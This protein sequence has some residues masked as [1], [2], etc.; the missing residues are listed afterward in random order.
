MGGLHRGPRQGRGILGSA[1]LLLVAACSGGGEAGGPAGAPTPPDLG[2]NMTVDFEEGDT[3]ARFELAAPSVASFVFRATLPVPRGFLVDGQVVSPLFLRNGDGVSVPAQVEVVSRYANPADGADVVEVL[4]RVARPA[5]ASPGDRI[6]YEAVWRPHAPGAHSLSDDVVDL[7]TPLVGEERTLVLR[8]T[9]VFGHRYE[10]DLLKDLRAGDPLELRT[11]RDG[12]YARQVRTHENLEPVVP[13]GGATG[14]LPHL[15]GV[16]TYLTTW[17]DADFVSIDLRLHNGHDGGDP[18]TDAD[19]PMGKLYFEE[20]ELVVPD[21][22]TLHQAFDD[23]TLGA[24]YL[25]GGSRVTELIAP[26]GDGSMHVFPLQQL[27]HRRLVLCRPGAEAEALATLREENLG[28]CRDEDIDGRR[29]LSWWNPGTA[30]Y[31]AQ[32]LPL[33]RLDSWK[34]AADARTWLDGQFVAA[35]DALEGGGTGPFPIDYPNLGWAHPWGLPYGGFHGGTEIFFWDGVRTAW[36]AS[37]EG[38]RRF[39]IKHRMYT[40]RHRTALYDRHG[41]E[42]QLEDW[43]V[44]GAGETYLMTWMWLTPYLPMADVHGFTQAPTFQVEAVEAQGRVPAYEDD[45]LA[46]DPV[47]L[48]HLTRVTTQAKALVWLGNDALAKDDL[49]LQAELARGSY[50]LYPQDENGA[51][52]ATGQRRDRD[53]IDEYPNTGYDTNRAEGWIVDAAAAYYRLAEPAWRDEARYWFEDLLVTMER[54]QSSCTG[55]LMSKPNWTYFGGQYRI[56]QSI[57]ECILQNGI[58]GMRASVYEG[59]DAAITGRIDDVLRS[60][61]ETMASSLT[62]NPVDQC[63]YMSVAVGP[64][65]LTLPG[66]CGNTPPDGT[67]GKDAYQ[68]WNMLTIG[69]RLTGGQNFLNRA[70]MMAGGTLNEASV[71]S[72]AT[73][74][75]IENRAGILGLMQQ[76]QAP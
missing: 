5:G 65:D 6:V 67:F 63:P 41:D 53:H 69:Y 70:A 38:Y 50:S 28:F 46:F 66:Y 30:R 13:V 60:S 27:M 48:E 16:H 71:I 8:T 37:T 31:F 21:G 40:E 36:A 35:R 47:D 22:W 68:S 34:S 17:S 72:D 75:T 49:R 56:I 18:S 26:T 9:D 11:C 55:A 62:W 61:C 39:Q 59:R 10:A 7:V 14:T 54:G 20:L 24:T 51:A 42:Y 23:P 74:G 64:H 43:L 44:E 45:L 15:M 58:Y 4:A 29:L 73:L 12:R 19:D 3:V 32:S 76:L 1:G 57:S 25:D 52:I 33:P 2:E